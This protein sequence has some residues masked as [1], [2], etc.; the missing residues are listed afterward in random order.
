MKKGFSTKLRWFG[1]LALLLAVSF[2]VI[3]AHADN[4]KPRK[5]TDLHFMYPDKK[6]SKSLMFTPVEG[7]AYYEV[8]INDGTYEYVNSYKTVTDPVTKEKK[9]IPEYYSFSDS[10][11]VNAVSFTS[12]TSVKAFDSEKGDYAENK[13]G[14]YIYINTLNCV[15][16]V[17]VRAVNEPLDEK[18]NVTEE[19]VYGEWSNTV[20]VSYSVRNECVF[21]NLT[22][23]GYD[24]ELNG[25]VVNATNLE[26]D[27]VSTDAYY[28]LTSYAGKNKYT[29]TG[30]LSYNSEKDVYYIK[31]NSSMQEFVPYG[32]TLT[33]EIYD[34]YSGN[35]TRDEDNNPVYLIS[36]T[37]TTQ[38]PV[39]KYSLPKA[40]KVSVKYTDSSDNIY[41]TFPSAFETDVKYEAYCSEKPDMSEAQLLGSYTYSSNSR[42]CKIPASKLTYGKTYY[43]GVRSTYTYSETVW[44]NEGEKSADFKTRLKNEY[45]WNASSINQTTRTGATRYYYSSN[46]KVDG[47]MTVSAPFVYRDPADITPISSFKVQGVR[48]YPDSTYTGSSYLTFTYKGK[49]QPYESL[50]IQYSTDKNFKASMIKIADNSYSYSNST[51]SSG[52]IDVSNLRPGQ[53][54][55]IRARVKMSLINPVDNMESYSFGPWTKSVSYTPTVA[56]STTSIKETTLSSVLVYSSSYG[57]NY[58]GVQ[59]QKKVSGAWKTLYEGNE[60]YYRDNDVKANTRYEY[61]SRSYYYNTVT[62]KKVYGT[63]SYVDAF[64][65]GGACNLYAEPASKSSTKISWDKVSGADGY[66]L[67]TYSTFNSFVS[68]VS[69]A[70][71]YTLIATLGSNASSYSIGGLTTGKAYYYSLRPFKYI[72]GKK[73]YASSYTA[74]TYLGYARIA[75]ISSKTASNGK[76]T[77]K[78]KKIPD[79]AGYKVEK[80]NAD[81]QL[82]EPFKKTIKK[83]ATSATFDKVEGSSSV[84]YRICA[85]NKKKQYTSWLTVEVSP[86]IPG[87]PTNL[88]ATQVA[89]GIYKLS[90]KKVK[91]ADAYRVYYTSWAASAT[92]YPVYKGYSYSSSSSV[93]PMTYSKK[94]GY[95]DSESYY[96]KGT[97]TY[98]RVPDDGVKKYYYVEAVYEYP[99]KEI[100]VGTTYS[101]GYGSK[102]VAITPQYY[103]GLDVPEATVKSTKAKAVKLTWNK[104]KK[105]DGYKILRATKPDGKYS[106]IKTI[107]SY[108]TT[109]FTDKNA[110]KGKTYYYKV[111][112]IGKNTYGQKVNSNGNV[113]EVKTK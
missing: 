5:I 78:W 22:Y 44:S 8:K 36:T 9:V 50:Q 37:L 51:S 42:E 60:R 63:Y 48:C 6:D 75:Q 88:K 28:I 3:P 82:W 12:P 65:W 103:S 52:E 109:S 13:S 58:S 11:N 86:M 4:S 46:I 40:K 32:T 1:V 39:A 21:S 25:Y 101:D 55:Y 108:K 34:K 30:Y 43:F 91:G 81:T 77:V 93:R 23:A 54:Y 27:K 89:D 90:W 24:D 95:V 66:E 20:K 31:N 47:D 29:R 26:Y 19:R 74:S 79:V 72:D 113:L 62:D 85:Y 38:K 67:F 7:A 92:Y 105:A 53:K 71:T 99:E 15:V 84:K 110:K 18:G 100:Y 69:N 97:S 96:V 98:I 64:T 112:A 33:L 80:Y 57:G 83:S 16:G 104:M 49:L 111:V 68:G 45:G 56:Y 94:T 10:S 87:T 41:L 2:A 70:T 76:L 61:R 59:I 106:V 35:Y 107:N 14:D 102:T 73:C 17:N